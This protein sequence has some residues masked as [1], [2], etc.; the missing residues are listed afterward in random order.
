MLDPEKDAAQQN[1]EGAIPVLDGN[2]IER[3]ERATQARIVEGDIEASEL[4][5]REVNR[6]FDVR[7]IE[8]SAF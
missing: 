4:S 2:L 3:S 7:L 5:N 8:T 6:G 1:R